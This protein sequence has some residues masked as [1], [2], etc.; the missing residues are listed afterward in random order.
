MCCM[1]LCLGGYDFKREA[2]GCGGQGGRHTQRLFRC[3]TD[4]FAACAPELCSVCR[5]CAGSKINLQVGEAHVIECSDT[6]T[7]LKSPMWHSLS[8]RFLITMEVFLYVE[9]HAQL[10]RVNIA[11]SSQSRPELPGA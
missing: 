8:D 7:F 6:K 2:F 1:Q 3:K 9:S 5:T 4:D 11:H 10:Q